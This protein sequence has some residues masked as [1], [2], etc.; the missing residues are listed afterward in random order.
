MGVAPVCERC[1]KGKTFTLRR[2]L[3]NP[4]KHEPSGTHSD[5][6]GVLR[7][8]LGR[9]DVDRQAYALRRDFSNPWSRGHDSVAAKVAF[10]NKSRRSWRALLG[11][12]VAVSL[13][14]CG[15]SKPDSAGDTTKQPL[16]ECAS[17]EACENCECLG[18]TVCFADAEP[19]REPCPEGT[20]KAGEYYCQSG[21][22]FPCEPFK[23]SG[24]AC[25]DA[26][27][28]EDACCRVFIAAD[29]S[30]SAGPKCASKNSCLLGIA[31]DCK[32]DGDCPVGGICTDNGF[33]TIGCDDTTNC[34]ANSRLGPNLCVSGNLNLFIDYF[35][36][37]PG[38]CV[39]RCDSKRGDKDCEPWGTT[40]VVT[41]D[42]NDWCD[43]DLP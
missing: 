19:C 29:Q 31:E 42:G 3:P 35:P 8:Q 26:S 10:M 4:L 14:S 37:M 2:L 6:L 20:D 16:P 28:C 33:C 12:L 41:T 30:A 7:R 15:T 22:K 24:S 39:P 21:L 32:V 17:G 9:D 11:V 27:E 43:A 40:C 18:D 1:L 25:T 38:V 23:P 5:L 34:G 13:G 36:G